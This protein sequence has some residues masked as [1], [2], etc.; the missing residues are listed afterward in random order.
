MRIKKGAEGALHRSSKASFV[1]LNLRFQLYQLCY[2]LYLLQKRFPFHWN[3]PIGYL[4]A[5]AHEYI[6]CG[7][8]FFVIACALALGI[9]AFCFTTAVTK[10][11]QRILRS[12]NDEAQANE[13]GELKILF[14]EF[15]D[16]YTSIKQLSKNIQLSP[17]FPIQLKN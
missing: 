5:V 9:A 1:H 14:A 11:L 12:I 17:I 10:E 13:K 15:I 8:E 3:S 2:F 4:C 7:Y 16:T 6:T